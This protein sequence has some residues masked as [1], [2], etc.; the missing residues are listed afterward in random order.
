[1]AHKKGDVDSSISK[2]VDDKPI[3]VDKWDGS[4]VKNALDDAVKKVFI[5][6]LKYVENHSL[7]D[8][9]LAI[10]GIA[11]GAAMFALLWDYLHPFPESR[12]VLIICVV[13]YFIL[14]GLLT[15]YTSFL[16]K[17]VFLVAIDKDRTGMDPD[18]TWQASSSLKRFDDMYH[19]FISY[20][21]GV[22]HKTRE[23][24]FEKSIG[25]W[26]DTNGTLLY[27][28]FEPEVSKLHSSLLSE[29]KKK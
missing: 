29:K 27:D 24:E 15:L 22:T 8:G 5:E 6:K 21:D 18:S 7:M 14:M 2:G 23:A 11:V 16:E 3:K 28:L 1:M 4:A 10:S 12:P 19:L 13:M 25:C 26:F 17:G 20:T 9:R